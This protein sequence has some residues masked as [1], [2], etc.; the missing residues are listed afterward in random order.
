MSKPKK[1]LKGSKSVDSLPAKII[2]KIKSKEHK[3][4][5]QLYS[6]IA[7]NL[8]HE[9]S[10]NS[11]NEMEIFTRGLINKLFTEFK[12]EMI[13]MEVTSSSRVQQ[14]ETK[15][16]A[17]GAHIDKSNQTLEQKLVKLSESI[18][19]VDTNSKTAFE[20]ERSKRLT[21][22]KKIQSDHSSDEK[23]I[24][25]LRSAVNASLDE[26]R[27]GLTALGEDLKVQSREVA[28]L[29]ESVDEM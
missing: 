24:S 18:T 19:K 26:Q 25:D 4:S 13:V 23:A 15:I 7:R 22:T 28:G 5:E 27:R 1:I 20:S 11:R 8:V 21:L 2:K 14:M 10:M 3:E 9:N 12:Q 16:A 6:S 17:L 29:K